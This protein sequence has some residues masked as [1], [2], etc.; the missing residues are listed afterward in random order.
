MISEPSFYS[1]NPEIPNPESLS[2]VRVVQKVLDTC[3][4]A[5]LETLLKELAR[6]NLGELERVREPVAEAK[7][8]A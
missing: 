2:L 3:G 7:G 6:E 1:S 4:I 8:L 5:T